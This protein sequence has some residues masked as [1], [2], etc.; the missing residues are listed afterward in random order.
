MPRTRARAS[1]LA[2]GTGIL[3]L[4]GCGSSG[5]SSSSPSSSSGPAGHGAVRLIHTQEADTAGAGSNADIGGAPVQTTSAAARRHAARARTALAPAGKVQKAR[6][7]PRSS[8]DD[9]GSQ[10]AQFNPCTL[11]SLTQA[12]AITHGS[13]KGRTLAR[14]GPTCIYR[15]GNARN[16]VTLVVETLSVSQVAHQM[17]RPAKLTVAGHPAYCGRLGLQMLFVGL[18]GSR[19][20]NVTA[21]CPVAKQFAVAALKRF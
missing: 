1:V 15:A 8:N 14:L 10:Q 4:A 21:P 7:T 5:P 11:V 19:L 6:Q 18:P 13:V 16:D 3:V 9:L 2:V 12:Q 20:L 17:T